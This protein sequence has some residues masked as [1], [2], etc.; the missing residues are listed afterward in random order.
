M[1]IFGWKGDV[2]Q[3]CFIFYDPISSVTPMDTAGSATIL[4]KFS[5]TT[6]MNGPRL[7]SFYERKHGRERDHPGEIF[8][9]DKNE[10]NKT[11]I[12]L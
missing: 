8:S 4:E 9:H 6:R 7:K 5:L 12:I 3:R 11:K 10:Q 1:K 2:Q